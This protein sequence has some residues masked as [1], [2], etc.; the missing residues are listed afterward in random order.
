MKAS[1]K[2][3]DH[4]KK[5][6]ALRLTAYQDAKGVW[7]IVYGHTKGVKRGDRCTQYEAEQW[8]K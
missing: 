6:E 2:L 3:I 8:L 1:Q 5:S 7:T 4:I